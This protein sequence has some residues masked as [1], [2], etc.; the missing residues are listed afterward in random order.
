MRKDSIFGYYCSVVLFFD[1]M[2]AAGHAAGG[3]TFLLG[4]KDTGPVSVSH[5]RRAIAGGF[6]YVEQRAGYGDS[7]VRSVK[8]GF[9]F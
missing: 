8:K 1:R 2:D 9:S 6:E 4:E 5:G 3:G 7:D